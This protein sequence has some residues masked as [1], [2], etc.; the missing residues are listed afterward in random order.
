MEEK[1]SSL[2]FVQDLIGSLKFGLFQRVTHR[3]SVSDL[4]KSGPVPGLYV[5][6]FSDGAFYAG[7]TNDIKQRF[8]AHARNHGDIDLLA[9]KDLPVNLQ[10]LEEKPLI[11]RLKG[12][13]LRLRNIQFISNPDT[14]REIDILIPPSLQEEWLKSGNCRDQEHRQINEDQRYLYARKHQKL[15]T[16]PIYADL[17]RFL[18]EYAR[19]GLIAPKMTE[20]CYWCMTVWPSPSAYVGKRTNREYVRLNIGG[21][22]VMTIGKDWV[23]EG[24]HPGPFFVFHVAGTAL[25]ENSRPLRS[26]LAENHPGALLLSHRYEAMG[27]D[28]ACLAVFGF[29]AA[30]ALIA[31]SC[32][33][34]AIRQGNLGLMRKRACLYSQNHCFDIADCIFA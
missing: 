27:E 21:C 13:G 33:Q 14:P 3:A 11:Q 29:K 18:R 26:H 34:R 4:F 31:D 6:S 12:E 8:C 16:E 19:I 17:V 15:T 7:K 2:S 32:V 24:N 23:F 20:M 5:L 10:D 28:Q 9:F 25:N 30:H 1:K 22:E